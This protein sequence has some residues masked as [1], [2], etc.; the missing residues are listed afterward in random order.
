MKESN[1]RQRANFGQNPRA[2][3]GAFLGLMLSLLAFSGS[4]V[5]GVLGSL[6]GSRSVGFNTS[7]N[8]L[9]ADQFNNRVIEISPSGNIVWSFGLGP[10]DFSAKSVVGCNDAQRIGPFTLMA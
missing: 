5:D 6:P 9:I 2:G 3:C 4:A 8:V 7:G 1:C 10:N